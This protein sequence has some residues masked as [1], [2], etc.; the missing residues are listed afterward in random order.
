MEVVEAIRGQQQVVAL[1]AV[2]HQQP[3]AARLLALEILLQ[4][5]RL[6]E[7]PVGLVIMTLAQTTTA[8]VEVAG[9]VEPVLLV[10]L[11]VAALVVLGQH[12]VSAEHP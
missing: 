8:M 4:F 6:K 10:L 9:L 5:L 2:E 1:A 3:P 12:R 11:V 7:A